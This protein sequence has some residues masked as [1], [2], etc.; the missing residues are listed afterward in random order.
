MAEHAKNKM[1]PRA[2]HLVLRAIHDF[3]SWSGIG[4][5]QAAKLLGKP[6]FT[7]MRAFDELAAIDPSLVKAEGKVRWFTPG[8]NWKALL[9][10][11]APHLFNPAIREYRLARFPA[12][13]RLPLSGLSAIC[14]HAGLEEPPFPTFAITKYEEKALGLTDGKGMTKWREW[15]GP[16]CI[17]HV[18]SYDLDSMSESAID[19]ISAILTLSNAEMQ[20][21]QTEDAIMKALEDALADK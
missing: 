14:H 11:V 20:D 9:K 21:P 8:A 18:M 4:T 15:D 6:K 12:I 10:K 5:T 19:P 16:T 17:I 3:D 7:A 1:S 2:Q 13:E